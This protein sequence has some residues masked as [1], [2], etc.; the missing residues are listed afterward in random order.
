[1]TFDIKE[2]KE[3]IKSSSL[4]THWEGCWH[5]HLACHLAR[6]VEEIERL[7]ARGDWYKER[8]REAK[9]LDSPPPQKLK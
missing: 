2:A 7:Q 9:S 4:S 3:H 1:M 6:A 8:W 5:I